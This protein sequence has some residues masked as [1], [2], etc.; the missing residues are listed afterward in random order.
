[1][2]GIDIKYAKHTLVLEIISDDH[3]VHIMGSLQMD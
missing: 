2:E 3:N 1:M